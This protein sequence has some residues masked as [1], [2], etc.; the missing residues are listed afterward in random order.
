MRCM[1]AWPN[2][3]PSPA[4]YLRVVSSFLRHDVNCGLR[5]SSGRQERRASR[6]LRSS[7]STMAVHTLL[8]TTRLPWLPVSQHAH[9]G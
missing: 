4:P 7:M 2:E 6:A 1:C 3:R 8:T 5:S 9:G